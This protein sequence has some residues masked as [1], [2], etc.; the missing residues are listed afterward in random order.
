[1]N[2]SYNKTSNTFII[3]INLTHHLFKTKVKRNNAKFS[4]L[5]PPSCLHARLVS[6]KRATKLRGFLHDE[7]SRCY[8]YWKLHCLWF[9]NILENA[10]KKTFQQQAEKEAITGETG[11]ETGEKLGYVYIQKAWLHQTCTNIMY[12]IF[13]I[14][15]S[16]LIT[17]PL[18]L[19]TDFFF[20]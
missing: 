1:M 16:F 7:V 14:L 4:L 20:V 19:W 17:L 18:L 12:N 13:A 10:T 15:L 6:E 9:K 3:E 2:N 11:K 5:D 8:K